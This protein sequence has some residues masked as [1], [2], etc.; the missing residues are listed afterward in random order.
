MAGQAMA[1]A[2]CYDCEIVLEG[3]GI[4]PE[5]EAQQKAKLVQGGDR[6]AGNA[7][8]ACDSCINIHG[9][10]FRCLARKKDWT[11]AAA[12]DKAIPRKA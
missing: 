3:D 7:A 9:V 4:A 6:A 12:C 11:V 5:G 2:L 10:C 1:E 8:F